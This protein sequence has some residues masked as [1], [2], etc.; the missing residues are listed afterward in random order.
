MQLQP[1]LVII[2][3]DHWRVLKPRIKR[4]FE[5]QI[6]AAFEV[7]AFAGEEEFRE[8]V[9]QAMERLRAPSLMRDLEANGY[10]PEGHFFRDFRVLLICD[11]C[12]I[13]RVK[14]VRET[15][16]DCLNEQS[17][18]GAVNRIFWL[19]A[20]GPD[21]IEGIAPND[22]QLHEPFGQGE[23][24]VLFHIL[25]Y[26]RAALLRPDDQAAIAERLAVLLLK[27]DM[28][29]G[30]TLAK[31]LDPFNKRSWLTGLEGHLLH[32]LDDT[33]CAALGCAIVQRV[34]IFLEGQP[35]TAAILQGAVRGIIGSFDEDAKVNPNTDWGREIL[36]RYRKQ[37]LPALLNKLAPY[38]DSPADF[39][40]LLRELEAL[41][42]ARKP[43]TANVPAALMVLAPLW[44]LG[45]GSYSITAIA[46]LAAA[47]AFFLWRRQLRPQ[48]PQLL[49]PLDEVE[50]PYNE[51]FVIALREVIGML[52]EFQS[53]PDEIR[54]EAK[55]A[56]PGLRLSS[57]DLE[58]PIVTDRTMIAASSSAQIAKTATRLTENGLLF[59]QLL[60][61]HWLRGEQ[62]PAN[63]IEYLH[64][65]LSRIGDELRS[66]ILLEWLGAAREK[67][68]QDQS[69]WPGFL[70]SP[71]P[72]AG[73]LSV[74]EMAGPGCQPEHAGWY[75][76][77][78]LHY[79]YLVECH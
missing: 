31:L 53:P 42:V 60:A 77:T 75:P 10:I 37:W 23:G 20:F 49:Q 69:H 65:V 56:Q 46:A 33:V 26:W 40:Y 41:A 22:A 59:A 61:T 66:E 73:S 12:D 58:T 24:C 14:R 45:A 38:S 15:V 71:K 72:P 30:A 8:P 57:M 48:G 79:L 11:H 25:P 16:A 2:L 50:L 68:P 17:F 3:G 78:W 32:Q 76:E 6:E 43:L 55:F 74:H 54:I 70:F 4:W 36:A 47:T 39:F 1:S 28:T 64:G 63:E 29:P 35:R 13:E 51:L 27:M 44:P 18:G 21:T 9:R 34:K 62:L 52:A 5:P 67:H 19:I 7:L